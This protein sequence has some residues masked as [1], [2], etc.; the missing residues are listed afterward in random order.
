MLRPTYAISIGGTTVSSDDLRGLVALDVRRAKNA[1]VDRAT[2]AL[3]RVPTVR[4]S[5][6]DHVTVELGWD[7][8][9]TLVFSGTVDAVD[10]SIAAL[11]IGC[12]GAQAPLIRVRPNRTFRNQT[13]GDVVRA[14]ASD[15]GVPTG[16]VQDG[17]QLSVY[18]ADP[19]STSLGHC[20][21]LARRSGT[22][23]SATEAGELAF[24]RFAS[25]SPDLTFTYGA[26]VLAATVRRTEPP[27]G[28]SVVPESPASGM[29]EDTASWFS[30]D[31]SSFLGQAGG[32]AVAVLSD[33]V[34]RT[35]QAA[36]TAASA[37]LDARRRDAVEGHLDLP[38]HPEIRLD[39]AVALEGMPDGSLDDTYQVL[40][41]RH[42]L[43]RRR[44][45]RTRV[46]VGGMPGGPA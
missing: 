17:I 12:V 34:L 43:D 45:F 10:A 18:L 46:A 28:V 26:D 2:V 31:P 6:G 29:G 33:P 1:G 19:S 9:T 16:T 35:K 42:V 4:A 32:T 41:V 27:E 44:G 8:D 23:L 5:V 3:G 40:A 15:A 30:K 7:G 24:A 11:G 25:T 36:D 38:G 37:W 22:D 39:M 13:A 14:L 20:L 21:G